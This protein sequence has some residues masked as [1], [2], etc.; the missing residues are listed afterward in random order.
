[1]TKESNYIS[2]MTLDEIEAIKKARA[3]HTSKAIGE[4]LIR[5]GSLTADIVDDFPE[6]LT[7]DLYKL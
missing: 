4:A 5:E 2:N 7:K 3:T 1:M 6:L